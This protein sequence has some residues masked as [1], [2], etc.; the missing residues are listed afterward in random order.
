MEKYFILN[1]DDFGLSTGSNNAIL[2]GYTNGF[3]K[4]TSICTNGDEV[5]HAIKEVLPQCPGLGVGVHLNIIEGKS[6]TGPSVLTDKEGNF[7]KGFIHLMVQSRKPSYARAIEAEFRAQIE[8][9]LQYKAIGQIDHVDSHVHTHAIPKIFAIALRLAVEY[10][11]PYIRTQYEKMY[12]VPGKIFRISFFVNI[13]KIILL[14]TFTIKN[15]RLLKK[16]P[17]KTNNFIIGVGYTGMMDRTTITGA[18]NTIKKT[19]I[20]EAVI[21]PNTDTHIEEWNITKDK[22]LENRILSA[23]YAIKNYGEI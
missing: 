6:L 8:K 23:G 2:T 16:S 22:E 13:L 4:S 17:I 1:A 18:L 7:N 3:L 10:K 21:H 14:N 5:E 20:L 15:R 11:I 9:G 19:A 12:L